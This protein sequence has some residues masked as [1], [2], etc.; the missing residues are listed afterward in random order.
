MAHISNVVFRTPTAFP[1]FPDIDSLAFFGGLH[2]RRYLHYHRALSKPFPF[3][4]FYTLEVGNEKG[5]RLLIAAESHPGSQS[6][7]AKRDRYFF[8]ATLSRST[9]SQSFAAS[10]FRRFNKA[11]RGALMSGLSSFARV[12][13]WLIIAREIV[14]VAIISFVSTGAICA[15]V[16]QMVG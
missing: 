11:A 14:G 3:A 7:F 9:A 1:P 12:C 13:I 10:S 6:I 8:A 15:A 2:S 4:I 16:W 5:G